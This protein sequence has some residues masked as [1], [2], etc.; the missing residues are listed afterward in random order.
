MPQYVNEFTDT[1]T[2]VV[3]RDVVPWTVD[4][5]KAHIA[6]LRWQH[7]TRGIMVG[8]WFVATERSERGTLIGMQ[9]N[10]TINPQLV[11][12][13]KPRGGSSTYLLN[14]GQVI[15][16]CQCAAWYI[17]AC[18][19]T[20]KALCDAIDAGADLE[21]IAAFSDWPQTEFTEEAE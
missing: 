19:A 2:G 18:F 21:A 14:A 11:I 13:Y 10:V 20:E 15:R 7:E 9:L 4:T 8:D 16:I 17:E 6:D 12:N 3:T 5:L 1:R